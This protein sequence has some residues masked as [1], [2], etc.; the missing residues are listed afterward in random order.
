[1]VAL[2]ALAA[3]ACRVDDRADWLSDPVPTPQVFAS[4]I[5]SDGL[6][7]YGITFT[8]DGREAYFTR[9]ARR[10]PSL[11]FVSTYSDE[12]GWGEPS[13]AGFA[14]EGDEAPFISRDGTQLLFSSRRPLPGSFDRSANIWTMTREGDSWSTP[15]P[16]P[17]AVNRPTPDDEDDPTGYDTAPFLLDP[18]TLLYATRADP[19]FGLDVFVAHR[20]S[21]GDFEDPR[22]LRL[23]STGDETNPVISPDGRHLLFQG[24]RDAHAIGDQD[25]YVA[26]RNDFGW[27]PPVVLPPPFNSPRNDGYPSFSPDGRLFF[28]ASDRDTQG[29]YYDIWYVEAAA[30]ALDSLTRRR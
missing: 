29:G 25:L 2:L 10:G 15:V 8:P 4:G 28:F 26:R 13:P 23:N 27:D 17:G 1:M 5:V 30:L 3:G 20:G 6:R 11:I 16:L 22:P 12:S 9:R 14:I 19:D 18:G 21:Q 7:D 24:Y